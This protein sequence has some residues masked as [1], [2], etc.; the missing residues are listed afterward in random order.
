MRR[1]LF[2]LSATALLAAC[3]RASDAPTTEENRRLDE[4]A[5]LLNEAPANLDAID[6]TA[7]AN[8]PA[9]DETR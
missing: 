3:N 7:L 6:D 4:A 5:N 1:A 8:A 9:E 2:I